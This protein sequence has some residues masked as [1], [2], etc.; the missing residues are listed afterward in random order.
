[1]QLNPNLDIVFTALGDLYRATGRH[2]EAETAF[3][4]AL[5]TNPTNVEA[6][7]GLGNTYQSLQQPA[8]AEARLTQAIGLH[9]GNWFAYNSLGSYLYNSGRYR[10]AAEQYEVVVALNRD[11]MIG[12][13][14]LGTAYMLAGDF[15]SA[16]PALDK[17]IE[18]EPHALSYSNLG[19]MLYYL[20]DLDAAIAAHRRAIEL[21]PNDP[22][23]WSNLGDALWVDGDSA[24]ARM[25]FV[26][27]EKLA[28]AAL[29]VNANDPGV[30]MD[31]AWISAMLDKHQEA[32]SLIDQALS[33]APDD[34]YAHYIDGLILLRSGNTD[35]ALG[36]LELAANMG[37][38]LEMLAAEPHLAALRDDA[39]FMA[40]LAT[41]KPL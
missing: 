25:N 15:A 26:T 16:A 38:S 22:L 2:N 39:R 21:A 3:L 23:T 7:I 37:Y 28:L 1:M 6:L 31:L 34:P 36:S 19:L 40:I 5:E 8:A 20:G 27:A 12:F 17:A 35:G 33:V 18:I 30:L 29:G 13:V 4:A 9:P 32:R 10:A 24:A 14:N 41:A 11:N